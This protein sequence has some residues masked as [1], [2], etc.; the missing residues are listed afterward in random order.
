MLGSS[1]RNSSPPQVEESLTK[2]LNRPIEL[3]S[4]ERF[5]LRGLRFGPTQVPPTQSD[6]DRVSLEAV[7]VAF[8][9]IL[10]LFR[11]TLKLDLTLIKPN[12][13]IEQDEKNIWIGTQLAQE[14]GKIKIDLQSVRVNDA[15]VS[16][17][18]R[19]VDGNL[20]SPVQVLVKDARTN[21][22][23]NNEKIDFRLEGKLLPILASTTVVEE[24]KEEKTKT[25]QVPLPPTPNNEEKQKEEEPATTVEQSKSES[26]EQPEEV[27]AQQGNAP[28]SITSA[29]NN[30]FAVV[31]TTFIKKGKIKINSIRE[32]SRCSLYLS[33][34]TLT[35]LYR[36]KRELSGVL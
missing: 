29:Q 28:S 27:E 18:A 3:G 12:A 11:T 6:P 15:R 5:T 19:S 13:Y 32:K 21:F 14:A 2:A 4:V 10:L 20:E 33:L 34:S 17:V 25:P 31:G 8:D 22:S 23:N 16:L 26:T 30:R 9:P 1:S 36:Y 7:E 35:Y 24:I